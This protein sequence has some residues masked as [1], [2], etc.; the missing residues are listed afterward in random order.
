M[1]KRADSGAE[2][3]SDNAAFNK[4]PGIRGRKPT[5]PDGGLPNQF[6][7]QALQSRLSERRV[8]FWNQ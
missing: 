7:R 4:A 8:D 1:Y 2:I 5:H 3:P 6:Q